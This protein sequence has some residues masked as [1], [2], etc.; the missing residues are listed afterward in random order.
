MVN[1]MPAYAKALAGKNVVN[2][3]LAYA[4]ASAGKNVVN[5]LC[6]EPIQPFKPIKQ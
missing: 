3:I 1:V 4:K 6:F 2:T 5:Y